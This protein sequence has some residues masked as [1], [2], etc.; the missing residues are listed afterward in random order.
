MTWKFSELWIKIILMTNESVFVEYVMILSVVYFVRKDGYCLLFNSQIHVI[1]LFFLSEGRKHDGSLIE[2]S[3]QTGKI[4]I[5]N[6]NSGFILFRYI[7]FLK[8]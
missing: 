5:L 1:V 3:Y 2:K 4:T 7:I 8:E 6:I